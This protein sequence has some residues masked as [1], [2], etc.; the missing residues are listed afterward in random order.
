M[1]VS[2]KRVTNELASQEHSF[3]DVASETPKRADQDLSPLGNGHDYL[4]KNKKL[5]QTL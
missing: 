3:D 5:E 2:F 1:P 4:K